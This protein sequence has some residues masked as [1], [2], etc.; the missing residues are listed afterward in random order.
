LENNLSEPTYSDGRTVSESGKTEKRETRSAC[1]EDIKPYA[2]RCPHCG[3]DHNWIGKFKN[4]ATVVGAILA[5]ASLATLAV[6][7]GI[8]LLGSK[9]AVLAGLV[10]KTDRDGVYFVVSNQGRRPA[11]IFDVMVTGPYTDETCKSPITFGASVDTGS[12]MKVV[13]PEKTYTFVGKLETAFAYLPT[14]FA[15]SALVDLKLQKE[16]EQY[17]QCKLVISYI[18]FDKKIKMFE[19]PYHCVPQAPCTSKEGSSKDM[20]KN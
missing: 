4:I 15:P 19:I 13:E 16:L 9:T 11:T 2:S 17:K 14:T 12:V 1:K 20:P 10:A 5:L 6:K 3:T 7:A 8:E 18:D